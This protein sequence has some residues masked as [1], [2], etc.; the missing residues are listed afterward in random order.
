MRK[1]C[2]FAALLW[3]AMSGG[4]ARAETPDL[5][6][7]VGEALSYKL[8]WGV[9]PVGRA[10]ITTEWVQREGKALIRLRAEAKSSRLLAAIY[11]LHDIVESIVDAESFLP[12]EFTMM[13]N[14]GRLHRTDRTVFDREA[15]VGRL[16]GEQTRKGRYRKRD[17][18]Y[19]IE[20]DTRD[21]LSFLYYMRKFSP[22][23][24]EN[25]EFR[26][27][28]GEKIYG[29]HMGSI[30]EDT[31]KVNNHGRVACARYFPQAALEKVFVQ[32]GKMWLWVSDDA[33]QILVEA[34]ARGKVFSTVRAVLTGVSGPGDDHWV[35][36]GRSAENDLD[37][38]AEEKVLRDD[39]SGYEL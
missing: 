23:E 29:L 37:D 35:R 14:E 22:E 25:K 28:T 38:T 4:T 3:M 36:P 2:L 13:Q 10:W 21:I 11:P 34:K 16:T 39:A 30:T 33:R 1:T 8:Y 26:V 19:P 32:K 15:M 27:M 17:K 12:V 9:L 18:E 20:A 31:I 24:K 7:P 6:F 5:W